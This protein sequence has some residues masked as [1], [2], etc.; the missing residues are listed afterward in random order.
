[1]NTAGYSAVMKIKMTDNNDD[2]DILDRTFMVAAE[3]RVTFV[4]SENRVA[5]VIA[6]KPVKPE[7]GE[8]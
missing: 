1:M 2:N 7:V 8:A 4:E 6:H 5:V 3:S